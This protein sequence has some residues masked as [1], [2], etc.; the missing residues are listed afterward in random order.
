MHG[1]SILLLSKRLIF[2]IIR[3]M[4]E[5]HAFERAR[6]LFQSLACAVAAVFFRASLVLR[7]RP[8][9]EL[10][11][12]C[13]C[14]LFQSLAF[15]VVTAFEI[16]PG[17]PSGLLPPAVASCGCPPPPPLI[18]PETVLIISTALSPVRPAA[19]SPIPITSETLPSYSEPI[20]T[21]LQSSDCLI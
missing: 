13:G 19:L 3:I 10:R 9:S 21:I 17:S 14:V 11:C 4:S 18:S 2:R 8:F 6:G 7:Q 16:A 12:R 5:W 15:A 20:T 1:Q